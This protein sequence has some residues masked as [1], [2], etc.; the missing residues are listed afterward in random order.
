MQEN[1]AR[2]GPW[3]KLNPQPLSLPEFVREVVDRL[4]R[5][6]PANIEIQFEADEAGGVVEADPGAVRQIVMNLATNARDAMPQGGMLYLEVRR[7]RLHAADRPVH[8]RG[9]PGPHVRVA[10]SDNPVGVDAPTH[11]P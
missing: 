8:A 1:E 6:L 3:E 11:A 2:S 7:T 5:L 4:R 9:E 10:G